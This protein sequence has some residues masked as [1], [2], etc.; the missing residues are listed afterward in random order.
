[1]ALVEPCNTDGQDANLSS[2]SYKMLPPRIIDVASI[3]GVVG[4]V[5]IGRGKEWGIIDRSHDLLDPAGNED[6]EL[7]D[8]M[9]D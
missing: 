9:L 2:V 5:K 4:R 3:S 6:P 8:E 1:L 7:I